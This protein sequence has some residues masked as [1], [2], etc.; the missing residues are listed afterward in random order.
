MGIVEVCV[1]GSWFFVCDSVWDDNDASLICNQLGYS[2]DGNKLFVFNNNN[3]IHYFF[4]GA[5][6]L[7]GYSYYSRYTTVIHLMECLGNESSILDCH[8]TI[9][10]RR[11]LSG[12]ADIVCQGN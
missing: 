7:S 2:T 4:I 11:C 1:N 10:N 5:V 3:T 8:Y 12:L 6:A 9:S